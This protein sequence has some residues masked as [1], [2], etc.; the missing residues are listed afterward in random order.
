MRANEAIMC[1]SYK[2][3]PT[4]TSKQNNSPN[5]RHSLSPIFII[6]RCQNNVG[7]MLDDCLQR[8]PN[9][10]PTLGQCFVL[11]GTMQSLQCC[12][13][14]R[15]AERYAREKRPDKCVTALSLVDMLILLI[16]ISTVLQHAQF[17]ARMKNNFV[18]F[19]VNIFTKT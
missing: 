11:L 9:K 10:I 6:R 19:T 1:T 2:N 15:I 8:W 13:V 17:F 18:L 5:Y 4:H 16:T 7:M 14:K 3:K 12:I